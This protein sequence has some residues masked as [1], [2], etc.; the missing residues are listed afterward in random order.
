MLV[1]SRHCRICVAEDVPGVRI[2]AY[3]IAGA[4][5]RRRRHGDRQYPLA[6]GTVR[7]PRQY[8]RCLGTLPYPPIRTLPSRSDSGSEGLCR[9]RY[10]QTGSTPNE[11]Q[12]KRHLGRHLVVVL[13]IPGPGCPPQR[14][15]VEEC[16]RFAGAARQTQHE[17]SP[18]IEPCRRCALQRSYVAVELERATRLL[19]RSALR[20]EVINLR[21]GSIRCRRGRRVCPYSSSYSLRLR[22]AG[23]GTGTGSPV[24]HCPGSPGCL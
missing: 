14:I 10:I 3:P 23:R 6:A 5:H 24:A 4:N 17:I 8:R 15:R 13:Q 16:S 18:R 2:G 1:S 22:I 19:E 20:L 9:C 21:S 12:S 11:P 7:V